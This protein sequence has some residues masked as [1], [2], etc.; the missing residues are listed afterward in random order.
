MFTNDKFKIGLILVIGIVFFLIMLFSSVA[1][2]AQ[3]KTDIPVDNSLGFR[4][5]IVDLLVNENGVFKPAN[6]SE[7]SVA[8]DADVFS[9][10]YINND[11]VI[12]NSD[13]GEKVVAPGAQDV[14][15]F[16]VRNTSSTDI[17][18]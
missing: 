6:L 1:V 10:R 17:K 14:G 18:C 15:Q 3:I 9:V 4:S 8:V 2:F 7:D 16:I 5:P 11:T 12:I 13:N